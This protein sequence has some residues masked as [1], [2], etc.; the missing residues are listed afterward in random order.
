M[1]I[2]TALIAHQA[3][4]A[5]VDKLSA[6]PFSCKHTSIC[7]SITVVQVITYSVEVMQIAEDVRVNRKNKQPRQAMS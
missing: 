1:Q 3:S 4:V 2:C 5:K 7:S 6:K